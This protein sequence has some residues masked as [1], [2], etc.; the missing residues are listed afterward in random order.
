MTNFL[1][2]SI[3]FEYNMKCQELM[4]NY[5]K[6]V[7][8]NSYLKKTF[9]LTTDISKYVRIDFITNQSRQQFINSLYF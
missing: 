3:I 5:V 1:K 8:K 7:L 9:L 6:P 4:K 2:N